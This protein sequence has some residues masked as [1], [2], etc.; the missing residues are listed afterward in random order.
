MCYTG[1]HYKECVEEGGI[2]KVEGVLWK[3]V[4]RELETGRRVCRETGRKLIHEDIRIRWSRRNNI[5]VCDNHRRRMNEAFTPREVPT[6][7]A[8]EQRNDT[9]FTI[10]GLRFVGT[11][12]LR[13]ES[14]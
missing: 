11:S 1:Q 10:S 12:K 4:N 13:Q 14:I 6:Q 7:T 2:R 8:D 5:T 9:T 3:F